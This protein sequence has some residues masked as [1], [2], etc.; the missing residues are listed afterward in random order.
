MAEIRDFKASGS[1]FRIAIDTYELKMPHLVEVVAVIL[2]MWPLKVSYSKEM[3]RRD[4]VD[5]F[6]AGRSVSSI[7]W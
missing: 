3:G 1:S 6:V 5:G 4:N 2:R 7:R